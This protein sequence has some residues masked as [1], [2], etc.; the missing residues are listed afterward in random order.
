MFY[1]Y[2]LHNTRLFSTSIYGMAFTL[3]Q[4]RTLSQ[5]SSPLLCTVLIRK[6]LPLDVVYESR[7]I[8]SRAKKKCS[9]KILFWKQ[10]I[11]KIRFWPWL[12]QLSNFNCF[13]DHRLN[14][15]EE[16]IN[17]RQSFSHCHDRKTL[18]Y[19]TGQFA[20]TDLVWRHERPGVLVWK[21]R[22]GFAGQ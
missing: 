3:T 10:I 2:S 20:R 17:V 6:R 19:G 12:Y 5:R 18:F 7:S 4:E 14:C 9:R 13:E 22:N 1:K 8:T 16:K 11:I 15:S 21:F